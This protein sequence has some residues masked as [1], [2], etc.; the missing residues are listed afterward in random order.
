[1]VNLNLND[2]IAEK[3]RFGRSS[4]ND[5]RSRYAAGAAGQNGTHRPIFPVA[6]NSASSAPLP[7]AVEGLRAFG[8]S[9]A[10]RLRNCGI[11][12]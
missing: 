6:K 9:L 8:H 3:F 5:L 1:M 10:A 11:F 7:A 4:S 12:L 2:N